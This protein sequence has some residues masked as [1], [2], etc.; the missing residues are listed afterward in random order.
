MVSQRPF[1][2]GQQ[3]PGKMLLTI[4]HVGASHPGHGYSQENT[5]KG[6]GRRGRAGRKPWR[7]VAGRARGA[8]AVESSPTAVPKVKREW[9]Q[10]PTIPL[11]GTDPREIKTRPHGREG[12]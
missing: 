4:S 10:D 9:P 2:N 8:D 1:A 11:L 5:A 3:N 12:V 6:E 7:P